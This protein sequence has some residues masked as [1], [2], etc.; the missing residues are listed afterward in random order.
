MDAASW[1]V[2]IVAFFDMFI[3]STFGFDEALV[4]VPLLA[5]TMPIKIA[6]PVA[7]LLSITVAA[8]VRL[9]RPCRHRRHPNR[10]IRIANSKEVRIG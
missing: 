7:V 5:L 9:L 3:P 6:A 2:L 8:Q 1:N 4:A 10:P